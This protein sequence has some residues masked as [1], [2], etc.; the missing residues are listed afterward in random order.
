MLKLGVDFYVEHLVGVCVAGCWSHLAV[1]AVVDLFVDNLHHYDGQLLPGSAFGD[2]F[3]ENL[4]H[5]D[6]DF[7]VDNP[8]IFG[9]NFAVESP[10]LLDVDLSAVD[11]PA[12]VD[13]AGS[14]NCPADAGSLNQ[15]AGADLAGSLNQ[16]SDADLAGMLNHRGVGLAAD[17]SAAWQVLPGDLPVDIPAVGVL[18]QDVEHYPAL[19]QN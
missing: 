13:L 8:G 15:F 5:F 9:G 6:A 2:F 18:A 1:A 11:L 12:A 19:Y 10:L 3:L 7:A 16:F 14:Q 4:F 17:L